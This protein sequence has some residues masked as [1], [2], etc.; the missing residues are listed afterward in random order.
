MVANRFLIVGNPNTGKTTLFNNLTGS[1]ERTANYSGVTVEEKRKVVNYKG[2]PFEFVDLPGIYSLNSLSEDEVVTKNYLKSH[3]D[4]PVVFV[5]SSDDIMKNMILLTELANSGHKMLVVINK[6]GEK[7]RQQD[8]DKLNQELSIPIMQADVRKQKNELLEWLSSSIATTISKRLN[9]DT[10]IK[11]LPTNEDKVRRLDA[12]LLHKVW[13][14][15][16]FCFVFVAVIIISYG[17]IGSGLSNTL[18]KYL[19]VFASSVGEWLSRFEIK[20]LVDFWYKVIIDG[21]GQ[22]VIYL[23]QLALMLTLL[24]MLEEI[25]YLPRVASL[26]NCSLEK[27]G[28]NG[29]SVF[30]L[31]MGVGCTTSAMLVTRNIGTMRARKSTASFLPFVGCSAK[32]PIFIFLTQMVLGGRGIIYVG[33]IYL[34]S[35]II[36][37]VYLS[38]IQKEEGD[39]DFFISE[40]PKLKKPSLNG[41]IKRSIVIVFDLFKKIVVSVLLSTTILWLLLNISVDFK[42]FGGGLSLLEVISKYVSYLFIPLGINR[43]DVVVSLFAGLV[44]KENIMSVMGLFNGLEGLSAVQAITFLIF[45][46]LYA[47]CIP[48]IKCAKCEFGKGFAFRL[49][50]VQFILAY[51][52]SFVFATFAKIS[53]I[54]GFFMLICSSI[55]LLVCVRVLRQKFSKSNKS[56]KISHKNLLNS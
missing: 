23:P 50:V 46:M 11:L 19:G 41:C 44:A 6:M 26:F 33:L 29:K 52:A 20:W 27:L 21:V 31:V 47:P 48:S 13:G 4:D 38:I 22:V 7:L 36:G 9:F 51:I 35:I 25:G 53:L 34:S 42:F 17:K 8:I 15:I 37:G 40:I 1:H 5:C 28:M 12:V 24:F 10:I 56:C 54:L 14:K 3:A 2:M 32:L 39:N 43:S 18:E 45:I 55:L 30:S 16:I 49:L